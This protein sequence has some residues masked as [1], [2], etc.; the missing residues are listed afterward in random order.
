MYLFKPHFYELPL[1][2]GNAAPSEQQE[3]ALCKEKAAQDRSDVSS[4]G[5]E[6]GQDRGSQ[7]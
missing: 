1:A 4:L 5:I 7:V 3:A 6:P 2:A